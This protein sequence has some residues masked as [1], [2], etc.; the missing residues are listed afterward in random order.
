[1]AGEREGGRR[2]GRESTPMTLCER[3]GGGERESATVIL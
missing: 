1:M 3:E 2:G